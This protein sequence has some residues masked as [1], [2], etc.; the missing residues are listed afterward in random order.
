MV[1]ESGDDRG[2]APG[3]EPRTRPEVQ[4]DGRPE[5]RPE[6]RPER[7]P[8]SGSGRGPRWPRSTRIA[9]LVCA[10]LGLYW[11]AQ[12]STE[13][14]L[15]YDESMHAAFPA[16]RM[17]VALSAG[18]GAE[19]LEALADCS[20][21]PP[22]YPVLLAG[23]QLVAGSSELV[24]RRT[25]RVLW[26][27]AFFG[28]FLLARETV[29]RRPPRRGGELAPWMVL[30]LAATSPLALAFSGTVF[31]ETPFA[32]AMVYTLLAWLRRD[33]RARAE[34]VSGALLTLAFFTK[35]NYGLLL[36]AV[37]AVDLVVEGIW[38]RDRGQ[39][40]S[41]LI[42]CAHLAVVPALACVVWFV[43]WRGAEHRTAF[44]DFLGENRDPGM[45]R[46]WVDR[47]LDWSTFFAL[48]P[49]VLVL[50][51]LGLLADLCPAVALPRRPARVVRLSVVVFVLALALHPFH[52]E[53]FLLPAGVAI[54]CSAGLGLAR[55]APYGAATRLALVL[56]ISGMVFVSTPLLN[57]LSVRAVGRMPADEDARRYVG[58]VLKE[59]R[60]LAADRALPVPGLMRPELE[61]VLDLVYTE[62]NFDR[63]VA[64]LGIPSE[65]SRGV[66]HAGLLARGGS[67]HRFLG[68][69]PVPMLLETEQ[70][71]PGL[72][73]EAVREWARR[74]DVVF[75]TD[76][77]DLKD[78]P[79]RRF[80][81]AYVDLLRGDPDWDAKRLGN[82]LVQ[83]GPVVAGV[84][85]GEVNA[86]LW[87]LRRVE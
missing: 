22:A 53:R 8:A 26:A 54:W 66:L 62:A 13:R 3:P 5:V 18:D 67:V 55:L 31:L 84:G 60:S 59:R 48:S 40:R 2:A 12:V 65:V 15:G 38:S 78:R 87:A 63:R 7:G 36:V 52:Q 82:I 75:F 86:M 57:T 74:Y 49:L 50:I 44:L 37:L 16:Q 10:L 71:D 19:A 42:R 25:G 34:Y 81:Q 47:W 14:G 77:V 4:P 20:R 35:F 70:A 39:L 30:L 64:W 83:T 58:E 73:P 43:L 29:T 17:A 33:G 11:S 24:L 51:A 6:V 9:L 80:I 85:T 76:P 28:L 21:Y 45:A 23:V 61:R 79:G 56:L 27:V 69:A 68:D 41:F 72:D 32:C 46:G 1:D